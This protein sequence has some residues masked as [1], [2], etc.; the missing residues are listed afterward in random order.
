MTNA[1]KVVGEGLIASDASEALPTKDTAALAARPKNPQFSTGPTT[2]PPG[3]SVDALM[4]SFIPGRSHRSVPCKEQLSDII[5]NSKAIL[6]LPEGWI[7]G[8]VPGSDTGAVEMALW[9]FLNEDRGAD[10]LAFDSFSGDWAKDAKGPLAIQNLRVFQAEYGK[11]PD[12]A[13]LNFDRDVVLTWN[14]TTAGTCLPSG[15][16]IPTDR[17]GV[18]ICDA[19]SAAFA[20]PLPFEKLD[21]I[22]WSWQKSLGGEAG[23]GMIAL[24][25]HAQKRLET[26]ATPRGLPKIF[27]LRKGSKINASIFA[28]ATIN[29]P[30]MLAV[31]DQLVCL[32][33]ANEIG[34][35]PALI[36]RTNA[37][38]TAVSDHVESSDAWAFL[39]SEE[40][41]RSKTALCLNCV[42]PRFL[43][44]S[45]EQKEKCLKG[46]Q[47][48]LAEMNIA[49]DIG[50]Y[51]D[52]PAGL[53]L[54]GGPTV[55]A[56]DLT[57]LMPWVD[58]AL[59]QEITKMEA[60]N[61]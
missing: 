5:S 20:M 21:V 19:T 1:T 46:L 60:E 55:D 30:S 8:I 52:A 47:K 22:T 51:R 56:E 35:L 57:K 6:G 10:V 25:P 12:L 18:V 14:G 37:N 9:N 43:A 38:Y 28:G 44:L 49:F 58:W 16:F 33:W 26:E 41:I 59:Y 23:H 40:R 11:L 36:S 54:W 32:N 50:S 45:S 48:I 24:S 13:K 53:R 61:A 34:G 15:D 3:W 27:N 17:T 31:A 4:A 2:K 7:C 39:A 29:T 42:E